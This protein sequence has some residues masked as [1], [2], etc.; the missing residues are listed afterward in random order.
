MKALICDG[1]S[2][3]EKNPELKS[4]RLPQHSEWLWIDSD[5]MLNEKLRQHLRTLSVSE[6][7]L[8]LAEQQRIPAKF[9]QEGQWKWLLIRGLDATSNSIDFDTVKIGFLW[10]DHM[11]LTFH[12]KQSVSIEAQWQYLRDQ[13]AA[14]A[15]SLDQVV[16]E[17][18]KRVFERY[19]PILTDLEA[20]LDDVAETLMQDAGDKTLHEL[21]LYR[22]QLKRVKRFATYHVTTM[23]DVHESSTVALPDMA[24]DLCTQLIDTLDRQKSLSQLFYDDCAE[25]IEGHISITSHR[26]NQIMKVLT[27][28]TVLFVPLSFLA[29]IYGMNFSYIP[30]LGWHYGY[31]TLLGVMASVFIGLVI[32]FKRRRWF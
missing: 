4:I 25:L 26:L 10:C 23:Q 1:Q 17:I 24:Q 28:V 9:A 20:D 14:T 6:E 3:Q 11:L 2:I 18:C 13:N 31:F 12:D 16:L 22:R 21:T 15:V 30:E 7:V 27:I 8:Q 5:Q 19:T 29:G 32:W